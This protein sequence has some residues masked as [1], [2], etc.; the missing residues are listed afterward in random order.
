MAWWR[1]R[2]NGSNAGR[3]RHLYS[4]TDHALATLFHNNQWLI[5]P[6][7]IK[8]M[9]EIAG[10]EVSGKVMDRV[11]EVLVHHYREHVTGDNPKER[12]HQLAAVLAD[13]GILAEVSEE[14]G[15]LRFHQRNCPYADMIDEDRHIC[16]AERA[17]FRS[18]VGESL[19]VVG[20]RL[21]GCSSCTFELAVPESSLNNQPS[22]T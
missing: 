18:V 14:N 21:D 11:S 9:W 19:T 16:E 5:V 8:A 15:Q 20:C 3:P 17:M 7:M 12:L 22:T 13:E 1:A 4:A 10:P 2:P 6:A